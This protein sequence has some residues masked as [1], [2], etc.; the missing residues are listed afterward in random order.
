MT[1]SAARRESTNDA[2]IVVLSA[3]CCFPHGWCKSAEKSAEGASNIF[4]SGRLSC[5]SC[6]K[7]S[8]WQ[9]WIFLLCDEDD[10]NW[11]AKALWR[12][13]DHSSVSLL[14]R[15]CR[16][17]FS[18][19]CNPLIANSARPKRMAAEVKEEKGYEIVNSSR[20]LHS[21]SRWQIKLEKGEKEAEDSLDATVLINA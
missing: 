10:A 15:R 20:D 19:L 7:F 1:F 6:S 17:L 5:P 4:F 2:E 9:S 21:I 11:P 13:L 3:A 18:L 12:I 16:I 14:I 8:V